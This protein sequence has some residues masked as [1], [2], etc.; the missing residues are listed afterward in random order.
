MDLRPL[1]QSLQQRR[2]PEDVAEMLLPL[3]ENQLTAALTAT[4]RQA[5]THSLRQNVWQYTAILQ[6]FRTPV[7]ATRQLQKT[8]E[9]FQ[10]V[11]PP[12]LRYDSMPLG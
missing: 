2:R 4:L 9:L 8:A 7:G 12:A 3:L 10:L 6:A 1:Y 5:A 11:P